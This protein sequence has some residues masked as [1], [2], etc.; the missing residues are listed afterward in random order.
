[1]YALYFR[2]LIKNHE[3]KLAHKQHQ[4]HHQQQI[5]LCK[6][7]YFVTPQKHLSFQQTTEKSCLLTF[8]YLIQFQP[9]S[10]A[11]CFFLGFFTTKTNNDK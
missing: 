4:S 1:M 9:H 5:F 6:T 7:H 11:N 8:N 3:T 10:A 2:S